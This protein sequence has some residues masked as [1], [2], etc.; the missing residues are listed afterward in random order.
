MILCLSA[1]YLGISW[2]AAQTQKARFCGRR[3]PPKGRISRRYSFRGLRA[4]VLRKYNTPPVVCPL[5]ISQSDLW[6]QGTKPKEP[7]KPKERLA[8]S[9]FPDSLRSG[10]RSSDPKKAGQGKSI[11]RSLVP[12]WT[13]GSA[14]D[15][16]IT[17]DWSRAY[18][19]VLSVSF[20]AKMSFRPTN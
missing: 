2:G 4:R 16:Q 6:Y 12:M 8:P 13:G 7:T 19:T 20:D 1:A 17:G 14:L 10:L 15:V 5:R 11:E 18:K 3:L 9:H